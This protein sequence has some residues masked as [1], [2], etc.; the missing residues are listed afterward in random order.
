MS[1][2]KVVLGIAVAIAAGVVIYTAGAT[3]YFAEAIQPKEVIKEVVVEKPIDRIVYRD[4]IVEVPVEVIK[5]KI[6]NRT[7]EVPV[8]HEVPVEKVVE[9][10]VEIE[11]PVII[12]KEKI[13]YV[14]VP[15]YLP[16]PANV[17]DDGILELP[18]T[19][20]PEEPQTTASITLKA[21]RLPNENWGDSFVGA[22]AQM[23]FAIYNTAGE[24]VA[25]GFYDENGTVVDFL[26][27]GE[28]YYAYPADCEKCHN[29]DHDVVFK[30]WRDPENTDRP[31]AFIAGEINE[32][33]ANYEYVAAPAA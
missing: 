6:V 19:T 13:V 14:E 17:S 2:L 9:K 15:V 16:A 23:Y 29:S 3:D 28:T 8:I 30:H 21:F 1:S 32:L 20:P 12:E 22:G 26:V 10:I 7:V 31:R 18:D 33:W 5:E 11:K 24:I 25:Q 27:P 4:K